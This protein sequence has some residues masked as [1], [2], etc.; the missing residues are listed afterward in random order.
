MIEHDKD[1][2][3]EFERSLKSS[4]T[5]DGTPGWWTGDD[6]AAQSSMLAAQ[7]LGVGPR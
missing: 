4:N 1:K 7:M 5:V 2:L 3:E 6:D